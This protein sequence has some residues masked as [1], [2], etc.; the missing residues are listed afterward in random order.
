[1]KINKDDIVEVFDKNKNERI[2]CGQIVSVKNESHVWF[3]YQKT[4]SLTYKDIKF[5]KSN[6]LWIC[7]FNPAW[8]LVFTVEG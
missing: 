3:R 7:E 8:H 5:I 4:D 1:M 2:L 6:N